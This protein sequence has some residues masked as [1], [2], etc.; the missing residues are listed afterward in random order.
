MPLPH[1][2]REENPY[3][4]IDS[5]PLPAGYT[6]VPV[7][8]RSFAAYLRNLPLKK[9]KTVFLFNGT[10]KLNQEAQFAVLDMS[11]GDRDLQQCADAAMRLRAEYLFAEKR[12]DE[13]S[14]TDNEGK[15]YKFAGPA[16]RAGLL[17]FLQK[18]FGMCGSASLAK[19]LRPVPGF[20]DIAA[21]DVLI[22]GGF[23]GHA[24]TVMDVA[25]NTEGEKIYLL[26]QSFMPAQ[27][28]HILVNPSSDHL[29][30]WYPVPGSPVIQT[31][32]YTFYRH[33]LRRW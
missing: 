23:P 18:V 15:T 9:D 17:Q 20:E 31:P 8:E 3:L 19:Q 13:L 26:S 27:D 24:A 7:A 10:P 16:T 25:V 28:I 14:F 6:R 32:E 21:G 29:S 30:P 5:I 22:R 12:W 11:V 33:E 4:R 2:G 1:T